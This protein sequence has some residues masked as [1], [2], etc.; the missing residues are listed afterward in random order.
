MLPLTKQDTV[1]PEKAASSSS[2]IKIR[3]FLG[4]QANGIVTDQ[5]CH[6]LCYVFDSVTFPSTPFSV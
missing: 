1:E 2:Q 4:R 6:F 5:A 3:S